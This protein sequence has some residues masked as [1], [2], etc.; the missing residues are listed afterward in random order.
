VPDQKAGKQQMAMTVKTVR[1]GKETTENQTIEA[2]GSEGLTGAG[3][4]PS[5]EVPSKLFTVQDVIKMPSAAPDQAGLYAWWF[6]HLPGVPLEGAWERDRFRLAYVGI[7]SYRP[8]SR[9][10]LRQRLRNHCNGP[11]ATSTLRRTLA[12]ILIDQ[13][14]LHPFIA[15]SGK[16]RLPDEEETRLTN[17]IA[18][19]GRVAWIADET[20]WTHEE[21]LIKHGPPLALNIRG[22]DHAFTKDLSGMRRMFSQRAGRSIK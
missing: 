18:L 4:G 10:T 12:A 5:F 22:N 17:W 7:A 21:E 1:L 3:S 15:E 13:L 6:D 8:E 20:P 2:T 11:I 9:R 16:L 14:A 19:H